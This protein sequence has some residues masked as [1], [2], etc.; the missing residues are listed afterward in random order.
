VS[1][2]P[3]LRKLA[4]SWACM[5]GAART[6]AA[7]S[8]AAASGP[9]VRPTVANDQAVLASSWRQGQADIAR[10]VIRC[11]FP[12]TPAPSTRIF[13]A[14]L[15][16]EM[17]WYDVAS[18]DCQAAPGATWPAPP[19][20]PHSRAPPVCHHPVP[21]PA[22]RRLEAS[23]KQPDSRGIEK[24]DSTDVKWMQETQWGCEQFARARVNPHAMASVS[25][26]HHEPSPRAV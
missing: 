12:A 26:G 24:N 14:C 11:Q 15:L 17:T 8:A 23:L 9:A 22:S 5:C 1:A 25:V 2:R 7:S 3:C 13:N 4:T 10:R 20:P 16:R 21:N 6:A 19:A 18:N